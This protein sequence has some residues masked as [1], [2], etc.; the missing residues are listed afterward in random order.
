MFKSTSYSIQ[1]LFFFPALI[2]LIFLLKLLCPTNADGTCFADFFAKP[3]FMPI[4][5]INKIFGG[6]SNALFQELGI[7]ILYWAFIGF[8]IGF[9]FD[10]YKS[11][12][13]ENINSSSKNNKT[14]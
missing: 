7:I 10:I 6:Y 14:N 9:L 3:I 2:I 5:F 11:I 13:A 12:F 1:G 8:L 4:I